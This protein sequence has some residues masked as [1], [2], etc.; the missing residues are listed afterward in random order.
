MIRF[1]SP[2]FIALLVWTFIFPGNCLSSA[3]TDDRIVI[4]GDGNRVKIP[5]EVRRLCAN[6][7][8]AQ[9]VLMLGAGERLVATGKFVATNPMLLKIYPAIRKVPIIFGAPGGKSEIQLESLIRTRPDVVMGKHEQV[10]SLGIACLAVRLQNFED[11]K[12][13]LRLIGT[14]LGEKYQSKASAF[15]TY[16][17]AMI[18]K[19]RER[20]SDIPRQK[21]PKIYYAGGED[22]LNTEGLQTIGNAWVTAAGG[23]NIAAEQGIRGQRKVTMESIILWDPDVI[24][25]NT[26]N[27]THLIT[28]SEKWKDIQA[29]IHGRVYQS[30]RGVYLWSVRSGEGVLQV[31][32]LTK[33]IHPRLFRDLDM[34]QEVQQFYARFYGYT[35]SQKEIDQILHPPL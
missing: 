19:I 35:L 23:I 6:G 12:N 21:R 14:V 29:V 22:G 2:L 30:P 7:A 28:H 26:S 32:W 4:D 17:D 9:M 3:R 11:I 8:L 10:A 20:T 31:P 27:A 5:Q 34:K 25:T 13:T 24:I 15:C 1:C 16:Y 18:K 33:H